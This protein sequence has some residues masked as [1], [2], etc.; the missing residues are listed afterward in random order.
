MFEASRRVYCGCVAPVIFFFN[1]T[2]TRIPDNTAARAAE[3]MAFMPLSVTLRHGGP[4]G[5][6]L[7][8]E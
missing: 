3:N 2:P 6:R 1:S 4:A 7:Q 5:L 8:L